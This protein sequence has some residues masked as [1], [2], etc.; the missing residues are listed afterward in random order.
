M[1]EPPLE[2]ASD[3]SSL[4]S[5]E[6]ALCSAAAFLVNHGYV[7]DE[8]QFTDELRDYFYGEIGHYHLMQYRDP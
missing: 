8:T 2:A 4:D 3:D 1:T 7:F 6:R 5:E